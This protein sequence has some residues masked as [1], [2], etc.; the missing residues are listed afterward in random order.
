M[1]RHPLFPNISGCEDAELAAATNNK[2]NNYYY[3]YLNIKY[4]NILS[5]QVVV[6]FCQFEEMNIFPVDSTCGRHP[7]VG[8]RRLPAT[9]FSHLH[10]LIAAH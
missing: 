10:I 1:S 3:F 8:L 2:N 9:K 5:S 7:Q 6:T 4:L